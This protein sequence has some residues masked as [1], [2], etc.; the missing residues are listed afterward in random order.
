MIY[1]NPNTLVIPQGGGLFRLFQISARRNVL[2]TKPIVDLIDRLIGGIELSAFEAAYSASSVKVADASRFTLWD[3]A[4]ANPDLFDRD[5]GEADVAPLPLEDFVE[6]LEECGMI[7]REWPPS[8]TFPKRAFAD[9]HR[10]SF[11]EQIATECL[12]NRDEPTK[13]WTRQK[14]EADHSAVRPIPYRFIEEQFLTN[15]FRD[16]FPGMDVL[17]IGSGTGYFTAKMAEHATKVTGVDY[18]ADYVAIAREKAEHPNLDF[19]VGNII[20]LTAGDPAFA[21][22][23]YD[24]VVLIDTFLFLFD[25]VYQKSLFDNRAAIVANL[26]QLLRPDGVLLLFD[27]HPLWLTPWL[28]SPNAPFGVLTEYRNRSFKVI[29][30]LEEFTDL[31]YQGGLR[32]RRVLEPGISE[33]YKAIDAQAYAFMSEVP[34]WWCFE[35]ERAS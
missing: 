24:Y 11:Y 16:F 5:M 28:G 33:E 23:Q 13:W 12:F 21:Q 29:P 25:S 20:D 31:L 6:L 35:V 17:D 1:W 19:Q 7:S 32:I 30:S 3:H 22:Q 4:H 8:N 9:R 26:R 34:Q 18:N 2:A 27:P 15:Y 14:F 10:G